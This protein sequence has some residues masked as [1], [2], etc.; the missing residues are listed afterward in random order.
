[1]QI[2]AVGAWQ[3][4]IATMNGSFRI[5]PLFLAVYRKLPIVLGIAIILAS[6]FPASAM[7]VEHFANSHAQLFAM[8]D[9]AIPAE[10]KIQDHKVHATCGAGVCNFAFIVPAEEALTALP[11]SVAIG[12]TDSAQLVTRIVAPPLP[13]P[14]II[15]LV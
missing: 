12:R 11:F 14:K 4:Q 5:F 6:V 15:I 2:N 10:N 1:M 3:G 9:H 8:S 13:P 7:H